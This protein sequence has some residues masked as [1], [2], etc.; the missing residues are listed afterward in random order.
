MHEG[1]LVLA[2]INYTMWFMRLEAYSHQSFSNDNE[3]QLPQKCRGIFSYY[4]AYNHR[5]SSE[6][7]IMTHGY[8]KIAFYSR[9]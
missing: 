9:I 6:C 3:V 7:N 2:M 1:D 4:I 5:Q 8:R